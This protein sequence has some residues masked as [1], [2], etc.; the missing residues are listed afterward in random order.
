MKII[1]II[2]EGEG[3]YKLGARFLDWAIE[4]LGFSG[5][6]MAFMKNLSSELASAKIAAAKAG[7]DPATIGVKDLSSSMR[8]LVANS[9]YVKDDATLI[10]KA[11]K[12]AQEAAEKESSWLRKITKTRPSDQAAKT[13]SSAEAGSVFSVLGNSLNA[14]YKIYIAW[15]FTEATLGAWKEYVD[16]MTAAEAKLKSG[17][18]TQEQYDTVHKSELGILTL[19]LA[20]AIPVVGLGAAGGVIKI[21]SKLPILGVLFKG[22]GLMEKVMQASYITFLNSDTA[23]KWIVQLS[24]YQLSAFGYNIGELGQLI[25]MGEAQLIEKLKSD[26]PAIYNFFD[27]LGKGVSKAGDVINRINPFHKDRDSSADA[28]SSAQAANAQVDKDATSQQDNKGAQTPAA[29]DDAN[30]PGGPPGKNPDWQSLGNGKW[31]N[32]KTGSVTLY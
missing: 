12:L 32:T 27:S 8:R 18:W 7:I 25:G 23:R 21:F 5:A 26:N 4:K 16:N 22:F 13:G 15:G 9:P 31:Y 28:Q 6:K 19:S 14:I 2:S 11:E 20:A 24:F 17:K 10:P 3:E 30:Y 1:E 29:T